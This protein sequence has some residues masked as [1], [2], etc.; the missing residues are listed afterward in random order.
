MQYRI[1]TSTCAIVA[2]NYYIVISYISNMNVAIVSFLL[3]YIYLP[4]V[5]IH[6]IYNFFLTLILKF[7]HDII[8]IRY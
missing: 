7:F 1:L 8:R 3:L 6:M 4:Y 2:S 5:F